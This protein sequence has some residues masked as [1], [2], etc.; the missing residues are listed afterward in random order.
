V[1]DIE[2][3]TQRA[4]DHLDRQIMTRRG[5]SDRS[6]VQFDCGPLFVSIA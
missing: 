6:R 3:L 5:G 2:D 1:A 4:L